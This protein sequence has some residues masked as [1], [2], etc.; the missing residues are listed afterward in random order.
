MQDA[1][2]VGIRRNFSHVS[3]D[4]FSGV[5]LA[6]LSHQS[7]SKCEYMTGTALRAHSMIWHR[8]QEWAL[9]Q[10][11]AEAAFEP[12][13]QALDSTIFSFHRVRGDGTNSGAWQRMTLYNCE[14][15]AVYLTSF[16]AQK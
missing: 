9:A 4:S 11:A 12:N 6:E 7:V 13:A 5:C 15:L 3:T 8:R 14:Y 2:A 16:D 10:K 1:F